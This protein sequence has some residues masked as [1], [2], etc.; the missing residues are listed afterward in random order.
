MKKISELGEFGLIDHLTKNFGHKNSSTIKGVGDDAA[1][2]GYEGKRIVVTTDLLLEGIHFD[3][4]YTP[5][6]HLGYKA[7]AVNLSDVYAM[8]A[9]PRQVTVS[10]G[11]S[12][13]FTVEAMEEFYSGVRLACERFDV[14]MI[15]GDTS[16]SVT[17]MMISITAIGEL[18]GEPV[19]RNGAGVNNLVCVSGDLGAAY[20]GLQIL[21][22]EKMVFKANPHQQP[23]LSKYDYVLERFLKPEPRRDIFEVLQKE[24]IAVT[25]MIDI[26]DGLS[27][28]ILHIC[29]QSET[30][31]RIYEDKI[32]YHPQTL[33]V[34]EELNLDPAVFALNGGEDYELLFTVPLNQLDALKNYPQISIIGHVVEKEKEAML[35]SRSGQELPLNAQGWDAINRS[36]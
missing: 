29:K 19:Y 3:L 28:E 15:G 32:P 2:L 30:G 10:V 17:G 18:M 21:E 7:V 24:G 16:A 33:M 12:S 34:A 35:V 13:K 36:I 31:V 6:K 8:M 23:D 11:I 14:D 4:V 9:L 25:A 5:M 20:A 22:R 1:V 27:S 26:S